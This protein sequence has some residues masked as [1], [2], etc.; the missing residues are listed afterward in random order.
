[1][2]SWNLLWISLGIVL[3]TGQVSLSGAAV[4]LLLGRVAGLGVRFAS[5]VQSERA[6]GG[7]LVAGIRR[8]GFDPAR[9]VRVADADEHRMYDLTTT[10]A[11]HLRV[12]VL[13]GDRQ[14][15]GA[16]SRLWRSVRLRGI[17]GRS[18]VSLRQAVE[19]TAL[20]A[21]AARTAG[22]RT[23]QPLGIAEA[24]DSM[25]VIE[26]LTGTA[27]PLRL[28]DDAHLT[29]ELLHA[30]WGQLRSAHHP[31]RGGRRRAGR[32]ARRVGLG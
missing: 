7:A 16:L 22:V 13:D 27:V 32:V 1:V 8:A 20:L 2:W 30:I 31:G 12:V 3:V 15:V 17:E 24:Q 28:V 25:L 19:R 6:Y 21:Y 9:L 14:V 11:E 4:A 29:D 23:P 26:G 18:L 10:A 5:G